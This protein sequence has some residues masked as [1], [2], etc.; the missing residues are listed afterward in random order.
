[1]A[2][3]KFLKLKERRQSCIN[4]K[5]LEVLIPDASTP[6]HLHVDF[7]QDLR[8]F[9]LHGGDKTPKPRLENKG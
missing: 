3:V 5:H 9:D 8:V 2:Y 7:L 6:Y 4:K 1:M